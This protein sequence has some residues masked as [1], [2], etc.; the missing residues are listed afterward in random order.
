MCQII[1]SRKL[2]TLLLLIIFLIIFP[3]CGSRNKDKEGQEKPAEV[4]NQVNENTLTRISLTPEA[5]SRLGIKTWKVELRELPKIMR[6]G[7]EVIVPPGREVKVIAPAA[8]TVTGT[9]NGYFPDAGSFVKKGQEVMRLIVIPPETSIISAREDVRVKQKEYE[10]VLAE[11]ERAE[12]LLANKAISEKAYE[13]TRARLVNAEASLNAA[14]GRLNLYEGKNPDTAVEGLSVFNLESP[15]NGVIQNINV[16]SQQTIA[17]S[18]IMFEVSPIDIFWLRVPVYSG[19]LNKIDRGRKAIISIMSDETSLPAIY[20]T[21]VR[22]PL[23]SDAASASSDLYYEI[24][25]K[26][27]TF[28]SGQKVSVTLILK[29]T[30]NGLV[31]PYSSIIYDM[32][33]GNW[34]YVKSG[35]LVYTRTRVE[36]S[37]VSDTLVVLTRGVKP[38]DEVVYEGAAE[39]YG[40]EFGGGK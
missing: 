22:G 35:P 3:E 21:P 2:T 34:I 38:G 14:R 23:R 11:A 30:E 10:V 20:A 8:G 1:I 32:Y 15:V 6:I 13:A 16:S 36:V 33:G 19:D 25:N 28:R 39:L 9:T 29:S 7:G 31:V 12:K 17:A 5:E 27:G 4:L 40:T 18:T 24:D 37:H 26:N